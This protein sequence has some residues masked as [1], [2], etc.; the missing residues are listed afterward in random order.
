MEAS[1]ASDEQLWQVCRKLLSD[2]EPYGQRTWEGKRQ[3]QPDCS[4][5]RWFQPLLRYGVL[6]WG[7]CANPDSPRA[8]L[9]T[10][11]EQGCES[12]EEAVEPTDDKTWRDRAEFKNNVE[13]ILIEAHGHYIHIE[14]GKLNDP[15][16]HDI[17]WLDHFESSIER[18]LYLL[19]CRLFKR[20]ATFDQIQAAEE[21]IAD[22]KQ[23][24]DGWECG[25]RACEHM[26]KRRLGDQAAEVT[27]R[28]PD[29]IQRLDKEFW[30]RV[31]DTIRERKEG[32]N[33]Y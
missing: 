23:Q 32:R 1:E 5:C 15:T 8:G 12:F 7:A 2:F 29:D 24:R 14:I 6:N 11:W 30:Q 20:E 18:A 3:D 21:V 33:E 10:F 9:L 16:A 27:V 22:L 17:F 25:R 19:L 28:M 4:G 31:M 13:N 26:L